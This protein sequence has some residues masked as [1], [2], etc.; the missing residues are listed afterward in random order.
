MLIILLGNPVGYTVICGSQIA[1]KHNNFAKPT[2][3]VL[4]VAFSKE[5]IGFSYPGPRKRLKKLFSL[6]LGGLSEGIRC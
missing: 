1:V 5:T 4:I 6:E 3:A 2:A